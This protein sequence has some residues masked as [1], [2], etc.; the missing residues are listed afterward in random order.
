MASFLVPDLEKEVS[1]VLAAAAVEVVV[2]ADKG[3]VADERRPMLVCAPEA[4][5]GVRDLAGSLGSISEYI[6]S[7]GSTG[8]SASTLI[9]FYVF[10]VWIERRHCTL[11]ALLKS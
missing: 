11:M 7:L 5:K 4:H 2:G 3:R 6:T 9:E 1:R 10:S 8:S